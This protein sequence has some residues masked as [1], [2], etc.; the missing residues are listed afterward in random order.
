MSKRNFGYYWF[1]TGT[2]GVLLREMK[3]KNVNLLEYTKDVTIAAA[4]IT[5]YRASG[6]NPIPLLYQ[7]G[8]LTIKSFNLKT[9]KYILGFPNEEVE[10]GFLEEL[11]LLYLP[12]PPNNK[13]FFIGD[14]E[15]GDVNSFLI[16]LKALFASIPSPVQKQSEYHYQ[17]LFYLVVRLIGQFAQAEVQSASGRADMVITLDHTIYVFEFK[18]IGTGT[19]AEALQQ[20]TEKGYLIPYTASGKRLVKTGVV[21]DNANHTLGEWL[22]D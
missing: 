15:N 20:I 18:L 12:S 9:G 5:E 3:N 11:L 7:S 16:R 22:I 13:G 21:F 6:D 2:P 17:S 4:S 19:A 14:L 1:Q 10:Y 8:Y